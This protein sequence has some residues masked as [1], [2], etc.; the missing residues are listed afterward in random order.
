MAHP[1]VCYAAT[2]ANL[3]GAGA[4][5]IACGWLP[6][7]EPA[8]ANLIS[9]WV[10]PRAR[11]QR[12]AAELIAAIAAWATQHGRN[13]VELEVTAG[14]EAAM[15]AYLR[16]GFVPSA[17]APHTSGGTPLVLTLGKGLTAGEADV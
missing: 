16:R 14:N 8:A 15:R 9:M 17:R 12:L 5:G 2:L 13:R 10:A 3:S 11:G 7:D 6:R 1:G 4:V